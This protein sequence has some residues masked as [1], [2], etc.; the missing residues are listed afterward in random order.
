MS[1]MDVDA[2]RA[3][4]PA[5]TGMQTRRRRHTSAVFSLSGMSSDIT[6][7]WARLPPITFNGKLFPRVRCLSLDRSY[8]TDELVEELFEWK[9][10]S[11]EPLRE[12]L[13]DVF[14]FPEMVSIAG[15][16]RDAAR[17]RKI[18]MIDASS[19]EV[20]LLTA[21]G[22]ALAFRAMEKLDRRAWMT[23]SSAGTLKR[24]AALTRLQQTEP[25]P[26]EESEEEEDNDDPD[27]DTPEARRRRRRKARGASATGGRGRGR[28]RGDRQK[29]QVNVEQPVDLAALAAGDVDPEESVSV[30]RR[31]RAMVARMLQRDLALLRHEVAELRTG[32]EGA[33][34]EI[35][36]MRSLFTEATGVAVP[37]AEPC[38]PAEPVFT[39]PEVAT[40]TPTLESPASASAAADS[41]DHDAHDAHAAPSSSSAAP[42]AA[43]A[44]AAAP[45]AADAEHKPEGPM[46]VVSS[47][48][49]AP[50]QAAPAA[51]DAPSAPEQPKAQETPVPAPTQQEQQEQKEQQPAP[52]AAAPETAAAPEAAQAQDQA[53]APAP[54]PAAEEAA[55]AQ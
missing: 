31:R 28:G 36:N 21:R 55:P 14:R 24:I 38:K 19:D 44:A 15:A 41:H 4:E 5:T 50:A 16:S 23:A 12:G 49:P 30:L 6:R 46:D 33:H 47:P 53:Q 20:S 13:R 1:S 22:V 11:G 3:A 32:I 51:A 2:G 40:P 54:A 35:G 43:A 10:E 9:S 8:V 25:V 45:K 42:D 7:K 27:L 37:V 39:T 17:L 48:S 18:G 29:R 52:A 26:T 34:S